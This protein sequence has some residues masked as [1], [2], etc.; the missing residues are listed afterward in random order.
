MHGATSPTVPSA[1][2]ARWVC[3]ER[4]NLVDALVKA[5]NKHASVTS[6]LTELAASGY[7]L[8]FQDA[9]MTCT[10]TAEEVRTLRFALDDHIR[11]HGCLNPD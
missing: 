3:I 8:A 1:S 5:V 4:L 2:P 11:Q 6:R 10:C 9:L 7:R